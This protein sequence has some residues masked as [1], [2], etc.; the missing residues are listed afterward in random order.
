MSIVT[1]TQIGDYMMPEVAVIENKSMTLG[2]YGRMRKAYLKEHRPTLWNSLILS[3]KLYSHLREIEVTANERMAQMIPEL[4]Q[5]NGVTEEL[6]ATDPLRWTG[7]MNN[8]KAV[9]E[10]TVLTEIIYS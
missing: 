8:L 1:Y 9:A 6:K 2:R 3:E 4:M 5:A 10:E 7:L